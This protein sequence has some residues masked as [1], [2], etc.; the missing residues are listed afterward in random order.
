MQVSLYRLQGGGYQTSHIDPILNKRVRAKFKAYSKA[1][2][3]QQSKTL[4][5]RQANFT[6]MSS[7]PLGEFIPQY[8]KVNP[9]A[10]MFRR[11]PW[12]YKSFVETF[13][14]MPVGEISKMHL[15]QWL[16][17]VKKE[18]DYSARTMHHLKY[19]FNPFFTYLFNLGVIE[20]NPMVQVKMNRNG[21]RKNHRVYLAET[22]VQ[23]IMKRFKAASPHEIYPVAYFQLH[24]A[25]YI[26]EVVKLKWEH[27]DLDSTTASFPA[28]GSTSDRKL[29]LSP[30]LLELLQSLPRRGEYVFMREDGQ[31]WSVV[32]YYR[33]FSKVRTQIAFKRNFDSSDFRHAFAYYFLRKGGM[34]AHLQALLGHR[35]IEMTVY[36]YGGIIDK[37][38][39][40]T[41]PYNF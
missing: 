11:S 32:S 31:P 7:T 26:G 30:Q 19:C 21:H 39:E 28:T 22:E 8:L 18:K 3:H 27:V 5:L 2:G 35:S 12:V 36:M 38:S 25:A 9:R 15:G 40:K 6:A 41:T 23:E 37:K 34:L 14:K 33:K 4:E 13:A 1:K 16:D 20:K 17:R 29:P 24:T 10:A